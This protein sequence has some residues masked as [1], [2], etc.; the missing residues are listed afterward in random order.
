MRRAVF[1]LASVAT[2]VGFSS[3]AG[4]GSPS[5]QHW[6]RAKAVPTAVPQQSNIVHVEDDRL[7]WNGQETSEA[8]LRE[9]LSIVANVMN[10]QPLIV[11]SH[12]PSAS[13][14]RIA[15][16]RALIDEVVDCSPEECLEVIT[17]NH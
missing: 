15:K 17:P 16:T 7:L 3:T 11:L 5:V 6:S 12:S 10:P 2:A 1:I 8:R 4:V 9:F 14:A 13:S